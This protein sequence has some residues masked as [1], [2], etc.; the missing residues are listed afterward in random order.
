LHTR[1]SIRNPLEFAAIKETEASTMADP[2]PKPNP[3]P[4]EDDL[5]NPKQQ[6]QNLDHD[7]RERYPNEQGDTQ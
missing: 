4:E 3:K 6:E 1:H 7:G 5:N 2:Q